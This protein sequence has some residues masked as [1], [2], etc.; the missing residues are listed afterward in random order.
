MEAMTRN[1]NKMMTNARA[2]GRGLND[3]GQDSAIAQEEL[4]KRSY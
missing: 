1:W 3:M 2:M 4:R